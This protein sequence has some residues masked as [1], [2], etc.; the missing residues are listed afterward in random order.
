MIVNS[1]LNTHFKQSSHE[2]YSQIEYKLKQRNKN[3]IH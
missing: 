3:I 1:I 2:Y